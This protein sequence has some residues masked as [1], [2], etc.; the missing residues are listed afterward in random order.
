MITRIWTDRYLET[1]VSR[2]FPQLP[3]KWSL[4]VAQQFLAAIGVQG[5]ALRF[6]AME[7]RFYGNPAIWIDYEPE[8]KS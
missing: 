1:L 5:K 6:G 8:E 2:E 4:E 7:D 3:E